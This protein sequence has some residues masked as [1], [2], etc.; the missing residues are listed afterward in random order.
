[1]IL[2]YFFLNLQGAPGP[3]GPPGPAGANGDKVKSFLS[4][5]MSVRSKQRIAAI[6]LNHLNIY[7]SPKGFSFYFLWILRD[8][9][10]IV[11][12]V[13]SDIIKEDLK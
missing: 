5:A 7:T 13:K 12:N 3:S 9:S 6:T 8:E 4:T 1:M 2:W 11:I 10:H